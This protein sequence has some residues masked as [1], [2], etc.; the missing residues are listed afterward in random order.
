M[1]CLN[2]EETIG[3]CVEKAVRALTRLNLPWE[4]IVV[5]NGS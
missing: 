3:T 2:E 4:V 1:P 5:D